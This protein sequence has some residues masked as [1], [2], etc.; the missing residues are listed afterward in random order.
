MKKILM[1]NTQYI[2]AYLQRNNIDKVEFLKR[3]GISAEELNAIYEHKSDDLFVVIKIVDVLH[4]TTDT[5]MF[6]EKFYPKNKI[7]ND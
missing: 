6:R 5:F 1:F 2:D 3:C 4:I 7:K